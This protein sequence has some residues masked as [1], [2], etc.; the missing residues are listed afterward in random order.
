MECQTSIVPPCQLRK[1]SFRSLFRRCCLVD[2]I[3]AKMLQ[4]KHQ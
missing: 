2:T 3:E 1:H 4:N